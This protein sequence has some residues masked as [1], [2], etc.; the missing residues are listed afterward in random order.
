MENKQIVFTG[1]NTAELIANEVKIPDGYEV[2]VE[3]VYSTISS[4]TEKAN[5]TGEVNIS[6]AS[7]DNPAVVFPRYSGYSS[8]G[9]V[10]GKGAEVKSVE[11]GDRVAMSWSLH[12]KI[13]VVDE[14]NVV[15]IDN[16][17]VS[18]QEA[19]LCHIGTFPMAAIRK[20][21]IEIGES[22]LVMGLGILGLLAVQFA[23]AAG[24]VP[25]IAADPIEER[26]EKALKFGADYALNPFDADF[27]ERVKKYTDG[28]AN[29]AI[30][31]TGLGKG[32]EQCLECMKKFGRI[33]LLGC[34]RDKNFTIDWYRK[35][36]GPG[37]SIIGAHTNARPQG[38]SF[39]NMFTQRDDVKTILKLC[40]M[41]RIDIL[42]M[43]DAVY[44]PD[45]C[46]EVYKKMI[47]DKDFPA[48]TQFDWSEI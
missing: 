41:K 28:G 6:I 47:S 18:F 33:A 34:T 30:E 16:E 20:T 8:S 23:K 1:V 24:A 14:A 13:N 37:I 19:A 22:V 5:I 48:I 35:V 11:I 43:V 2:V 38:E 45:E 31:V 26:R 9:I 15:K 27:A 39:G 12:Q 7:E 46:K 42:N 40:E 36:H 32:L 3:T 4:G 25:V 29:A 10:I 17:K 21:H 44:S